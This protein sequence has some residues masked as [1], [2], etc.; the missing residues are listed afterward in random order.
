MPILGD[1]VDFSVRLHLPE[2]WL[3][4][5]VEISEHGP[6]NIAVLM[7][8][9]GQISTNS[10]R[11]D[12]WEPARWAQSNLQ[13]IGQSY[14]VAGVS[15]HLRPLTETLEPRARAIFL[16]YPDPTAVAVSPDRLLAHFSGWPLRYLQFQ[17]RYQAKLD[18]FSRLGA[19]LVI[20]ESVDQSERAT[21][22]VLEALDRFGG[23]ASVFWPDEV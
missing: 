21:E 10:S 19:L 11:D 13:S 1:G 9:S 16:Y 17:Q 5:P 6:L 4:H 3:D 20:A 7:R 12:V 8:S 15:G 22:A 23:R 18:V 2:T 14:V